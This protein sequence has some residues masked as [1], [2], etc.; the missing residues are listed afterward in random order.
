MRRPYGTGKYVSDFH[1]V[2]NIK[3]SGYNVWT[4]QLFADYTTAYRISIKPDEHIKERG[5]I[6]DNEFFVTVHST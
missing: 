3:R 6:A 1:V 2:V 4:V 5:S